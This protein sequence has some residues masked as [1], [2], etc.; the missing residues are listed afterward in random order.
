[1]SAC[2]E[3]KPRFDMLELGCKR[4]GEE[5]THSYCRD[6]L[7][8]LFES[9][10]TDST[11]FPPRC[12]GIPISLNTCSHFFTAAFMIRFEEKVEELSTPDPC[13]CSNKDCVK[14]IRPYHI[15][16]GVA[17]CPS[18]SHG[19]C[20]LCK[21]PVHQGLCPDDPSVKMLMD[22]AGTEK[23]QRCN[24]CNNMIELT[25]GCFHMSCR[26]GNQFCYLCGVKWKGCRCP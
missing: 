21:R 5:D 10:V 6:C 18:C 13:Y 25:I 12:C 11:L 24:N 15:R 26:C 7:Q 22:L 14:F 19:T 8:D 23:W 4:I 9:S 1:C 20:A 2:M 3:L 17:L 16:A